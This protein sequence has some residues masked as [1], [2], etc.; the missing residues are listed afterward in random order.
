MSKEFGEVAV[1]LARAIESCNLKCTERGLEHVS[2][3]VCLLTLTY[4]IKLKENNA[5][6]SILV[7]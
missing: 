2:C 5:M 6:Y 7:T 3:P 4:L 1:P